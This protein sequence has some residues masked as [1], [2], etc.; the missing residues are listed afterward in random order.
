MQRDRGQD[1]R[2]LRRDDETVIRL[3]LI[4]RQAYG[5]GVV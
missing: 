1:D 3:T 2:P 5:A 4:Q